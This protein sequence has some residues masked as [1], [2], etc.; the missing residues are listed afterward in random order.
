MLIDSPHIHIKQLC[1]Q[2]LRQPNR[3][4]LVTH[5][6]ALARLSREDQELPRIM[7]YHCLKLGV[8]EARLKFSRLHHRASLGRPLVGFSALNTSLMSLNQTP[9]TKRDPLNPH[10]TYPQCKLNACPNTRPC[11]ISSP[12]KPNNS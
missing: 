10:G 8:S 12:N 6:N 9:H 5:F 2:L 11:A 3:A 4:V 1:H 7:F